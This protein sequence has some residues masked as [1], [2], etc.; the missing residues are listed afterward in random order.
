MQNWVLIIIIGYLFSRPIIGA[1][2]QGKENNGLLG[3]LSQTGQQIIPIATNTLMSLN[4][5]T[6]NVVYPTVQPSAVPTSTQTKNIVGL[7]GKSYVVG[8]SYYNPDLG[9]VN[10]FPGNVLANGG[11]A[12]VTAS[13]FTWRDYIGKAVAVA[14]YWL[15][16][17]GYGSVIRV[18]HPDVLAGDYTIIDRCAACD[19]ANWIAYDN[20]DRIDF[21]DTSQRLV[22]DYDITFIL[23]K[24]VPVV[25]ATPTR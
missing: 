14:P 23:V 16:V 22:W 13:G 21:L 6:V 25:V 3:N 8:Y 11:C 20:R 2:Q 9:G 17:W 4:S 19:K 1:F 12:N 5:I 15:S 24:Y 18:L 10:C 7:D